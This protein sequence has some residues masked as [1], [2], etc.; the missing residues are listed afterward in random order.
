[1]TRSD[2]SGPEW[3]IIKKIFPNKSRE[4]T[5]RDRTMIWDFRGDTAQVA[6]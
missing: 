4:V 1:M 5:R 2:M 3:E 6:G